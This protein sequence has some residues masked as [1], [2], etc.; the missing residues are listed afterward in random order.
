MI[1]YH[2]TMQGLEELERDLGILKDKSK[3]I[4]RA[5]INN[6]AKK[7]RKDMEHGA[8]RRYKLDSNRLGSGLQGFKSAGETKKATVG[9]LA[10]YIYVKGP[11]GEVYDYQVKPKTY[12]PGSKGAPN[13]IKAKV[14]RSSRLRGMSLM[15]TGKDKYKAF[16]VKYHSGHMALAE[17]VPGKTMKSNSQKE[18]IRS[19]FSNSIPKDEEMVYKE[20]IEPDVNTVLLEAIEQQ[21]Q[22]F[23]G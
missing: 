3:L 4:L 5:A 21:I 15:K 22:R 1:R 23:L 16:V 10:A 6:T 12:F 9:N 2:V 19:L 11:I 17:R 18:A 7:V 20:E 8:N 14:K 13:W